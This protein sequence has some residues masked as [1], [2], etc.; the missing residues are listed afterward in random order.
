MIKNNID[1][2]ENVWNDSNEEDIENNFNDDNDNKK[3]NIVDDNANNPK[4]AYD[5]DDIST[6]FDED[7]WQQKQEWFLNKG[8][9][10]GDK[11]D[12]DNSKIV[13]W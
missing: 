10:N 9:C 11:E 12:A 2:D 7:Y 6:G 1:N 8:F 5:D 13:V 4:N 3:Q